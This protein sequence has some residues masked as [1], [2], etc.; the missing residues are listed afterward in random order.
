MLCR[1]MWQLW[2]MQESKQQ[3]STSMDHHGHQPCFVC[4]MQLENSA[5][6]LEH[7]RKL[8][9]EFQEKFMKERNVRR[10]LHEQLQVLKGNIRV[11]CRYVT[12]S[13]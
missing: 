1:G 7:Y 9:A 3:C 12:A 8:S 11:M 2:L 6:Q 13:R 4:I 5:E 10:K